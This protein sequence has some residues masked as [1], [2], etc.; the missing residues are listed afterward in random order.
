MSTISDKDLEL[1]NIK[2]ELQQA[3]RFH[4]NYAEYVKPYSKEL[5]TVHTEMARDIK[6]VMVE[7]G[8]SKPNIKEPT[9]G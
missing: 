8:L 1:L 9:I 3:I 7:K 6:E 2:K 4:R 5:A